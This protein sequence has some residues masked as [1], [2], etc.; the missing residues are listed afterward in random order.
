METAY[1][2]EA[3]HKDRSIPS[4]F[5]PSRDL[6]ASSAEGTAE[7]RLLTPFSIR[8]W[9]GTVVLHGLECGT[10]VTNESDTASKLWMFVE[11]A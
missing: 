9:L 3:Y 6:L 4:L 11:T 5:C 8:S 2:I 7:N 10:T 1:H